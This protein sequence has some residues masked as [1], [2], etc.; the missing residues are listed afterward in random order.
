M[1]VSIKESKDTPFTQ[2][3]QTPPLEKHVNF[4]VNPPISI[5]AKHNKKNSNYS[6]GNGMAPTVPEPITL[7][8]YP[9]PRQLREDYKTSFE[10]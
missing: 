3:I 6:G 1:P 4:N 2:N 8:D 10:E 9:D 7:K 5:D